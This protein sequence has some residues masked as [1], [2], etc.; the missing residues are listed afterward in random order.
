MESHPEPIHVAAFH[1]TSAAERERIAAGIDAAGLPRPRSL[2]L[3]GDRA[4]HPTAA[5]VD[6]DRGHSAP[7]RS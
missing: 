4:A 2:D 3:L 5:A 6:A 1:A 7:D